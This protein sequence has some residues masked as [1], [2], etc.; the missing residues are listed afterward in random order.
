[1]LDIKRNVQ[2]NVHIPFLGQ[3]C[4][5]F[6]VYVKHGVSL[7]DFSVSLTFHNILPTWTDY[8]ASTDFFY[9]CQTATQAFWFMSELERERNKAVHRRR[10]L[11]SLTSS[12]DRVKDVNNSSNLRRFSRSNSSSSDR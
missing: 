4:K 3:L 6:T 8:S 9:S 2:Y 7:Q 11:Q 10:A 5:F 12:G 1:M